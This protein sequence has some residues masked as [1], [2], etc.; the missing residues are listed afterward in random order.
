[1]SIRIIYVEVDSSPPLV[2]LVIAVFLAKLNWATLYKATIRGLKLSF[3]SHHLV[4]CA[5]LVRNSRTGSTPW[6]FRPKSSQHNSPSFVSYRSASDEHGQS[7]YFI[8]T[9]D[10]ASR[11]GVSS[12]AVLAV[13]NDF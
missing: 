2:A 5:V 6:F 8:Y 10:A 7:H 3:H 13:G 12:S 4:P 1:M 9:G 11:K